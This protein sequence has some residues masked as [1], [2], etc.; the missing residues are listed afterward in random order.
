MNQIK[1]KR[2]S[3]AAKK[4]RRFTWSITTRP[5]EMPRAAVPMGCGDG[6]SAPAKW[7]NTD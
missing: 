1:Q 3:E 6:C 7:R 2:I 5:R 4:A